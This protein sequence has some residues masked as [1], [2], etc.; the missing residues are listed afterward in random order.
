M[1]TKAFFL[2]Y[3]LYSLLAIT[4][5]TAIARL[6]G[7]DTIPYHWT[8][9]STIDAEG[10]KWGILALPV[11]AL[12]LFKLFIGKARSYQ[13]RQAATTD[14]LT[15]QRYEIELRG[16]RLIH[17]ICQTLLCYI[18]LAAAEYVSFFGLIVEM[19][20]IY[21][22]IVVFNTRRKI[23]KLTRKSLSHN[24]NRNF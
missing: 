17:L 18:T 22:I 23:R 11:V 24:N 12:F 10:S 14:R 16:I 5:I 13:E 3:F 6:F 1:K 21:L 8:L 2:L 19:F 7:N 20:L 15:A 4:W 9:T